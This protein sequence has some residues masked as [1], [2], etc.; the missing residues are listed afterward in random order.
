MFATY[1]DEMMP[2]YIEK[3]GFGIYLQDGEVVVDF[4]GP[5]DSCMGRGTSCPCI[6]CENALQELIAR[7]EDPFSLMEAGLLPDV[8]LRVT[9]GGLLPF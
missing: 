5:D 2:A 4:V 7:G 6:D 1:D 8:R 9:T 3:D